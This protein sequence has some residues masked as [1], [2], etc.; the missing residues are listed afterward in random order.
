MFTG[1]RWD[2]PWRVIIHL[3]NARTEVSSFM[4]MLPA[5]LRLF[6]AC[7]SHLVSP[8]IFFFCI[9]TFISFR[10]VVESCSEILLERV[11]LRGVFLLCFGLL[12]C[13]VPQWNWRPF[14]LVERV[15][16]PNGEGEDCLSIVPSHSYL[17]AS[18]PFCPC[19]NLSRPWGESAWTCV[20][21][22]RHN[23]TE[24]TKTST[25]NCYYRWSNIFQRCDVVPAHCIF[26]TWAMIK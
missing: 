23:C 9:H 14:R 13:F 16:E 20:S 3:S 2:S 17:C 19:E 26:V 24:G 5:V 10:N 6:G 18:Y 15:E 8:R 7:Y 21:H 22:Y 12:V 25:S 1:K 4:A 11:Q